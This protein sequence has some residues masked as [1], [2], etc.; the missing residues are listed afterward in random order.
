MHPAEQ[1][2]YRGAIVQEIENWADEARRGRDPWWQGIERIPHYFDALVALSCRP[3]LDETQR[4]IVHRVIKYLISPLDLM[5]EF[6]YG[7]LGFREDLVLIALAVERLHE[8]LGSEPLK[9]CALDPDD[10]GLALARDREDVDLEEDIRHH[11]RLLLDAD[12]VAG[13]EDLAKPDFAD[14]GPQTVGVAPSSGACTI[15][16]AG[17]GTGKTHRLESEL[18]RLLVEER[19]PAE[20]ILATTFTN[21]AADELRIRI[22]QRLQEQGGLEDVD[23]VLQNLTISTIHAFCFKL[24]GAFHH[25]ALFLK[26]TFSPMEETQRML[27]LFRHGIGTLRLKGIYSDWK[28]EQREASGWRPTDLFHFYAYVGEIYDFLSEDVVSGAESE[29]RRRYLQLIQEK[30]AALTVDERTIQTYPRYWRLVQE[31]GFLD[32]AMVLAYAE[33]LLKDPQVRRRVQTTFRYLLVDEYQDTNPI[34]DR[35]FRA[36]AGSSGS[37]FAVGDDDQSIYAFRGADVRNATQFPERWP[38]ARVELL[39]ENRR[40]TAKLVEACQA[41]IR[42]NRTRHSK[43]LFTRNPEGDPPWRLEAQWDEL[44]DRLAEILARLKERGAVESWSDVAILFRALSGRVADYRA[45]LTQRSVP[46]ALVGD[47]RFL[48]RPLARGLIKVLGLICGDET[49]I[50]GRA[51]AHRPFFQALDWSDNQ[52]MLE[53]IRR[54]HRAV[55]EERYGTLLELFYAI[56]NDTNAIA[57]P[58]ILSDLGH[59]SS[60]IAASEAQLTS[61][62]LLKRLDYFLSYADAA[63]GSFSGPTPP[64]DEAVQIMTIHKSKGLEFSVVVVA[65]VVEG[66][67]PAHFPEN[68]RTRLRRDLAKLPSRLDEMEEERR[69]LY[70]AMTRAERHVILVTSPDRISVFLGE[71]KSCPVPEKPPAPVQRAYIHASRKAPP[72]HLYHGEVYNYHFC[73]KRY[74]LENRYGFAGQ[75]IAPL[76]AG[77]SLHRALEIFHR[78]RRDGEH[79]TRDRRARIFERAWIRPRDTKKGQAEFDTLCK[80]FQRYTERFDT[81]SDRIRV[82][83]TEQPFYAAQGMGVLTGKIDLVRERNDAL[84]IVEFKFHA[85]PMMPD[86]PQRQLDHYS[87]AYPG[88]RP[89]LVV[90]YLKEDREDVI[91]GREPDPIRAE[92]DE[93]FSRISRGAFDAIPAPQK[94]RLCPARFACSDR[95]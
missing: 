42:N 32:H 53:P 2:E 75:V 49:K 11:L 80:I 33:A 36:V 13:D 71:F 38:G 22:R 6:I 58:E 64:S 55:R 41:L 83:E 89:R 65:D 31:E 93:T 67:I 76:R 10:S 14:L 62:D 48:K 4:R 81:D 37:V 20:H 72:L 50:T 69:V 35:I 43:E 61:P 44:P 77:Q 34:Q 12:S 79:V 5:P 68:V 1:A 60:F 63:A 7:P 29:L 59:L 9:A 82:V 94:C 70:V 51:R 46:N 56:L 8:E 88:E 16:F 39:E 86:Y 74:L 84:E 91:A 54:W 95:R 90:H 27:F 19:V 57:L 28:A 73:P 23:R 3:E 17:P 30:A 25:H 18:Q 87:L 52:A 15:V 26:G 24:I 45:A 85:N 92:L 40:S 78:L 66:A 21:K 47:R